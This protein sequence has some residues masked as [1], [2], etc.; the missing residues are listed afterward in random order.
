MLLHNVSEQGSL[1]YEGE[2]EKA[3]KRTVRDSPS[4]PA[5]TLDYDS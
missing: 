5:R 1:L 3:E 2:K 4:V